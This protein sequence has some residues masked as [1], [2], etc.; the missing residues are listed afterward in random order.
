MLVCKGNFRCQVEDCPKCEI[1]LDEERT[2]TEARLKRKPPPETK[3][4]RVTKFK[5][6]RRKKF[7]KEAVKQAKEDVDKGKILPMNYYFRPK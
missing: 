7:A 1:L 5:V 6:K 2:R 4:E 3:E